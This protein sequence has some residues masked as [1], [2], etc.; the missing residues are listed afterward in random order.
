MKLNWLQSLDVESQVVEAQISAEAEDVVRSHYDIVVWGDDIE[1]FMSEVRY[2]MRN[3][4]G[5]SVRAST[6]ISDEIDS[7]V[8]ELIA[9]DSATRPQGPLQDIHLNEDNP[10]DTPHHQ[11]LLGTYGSRNSPDTVVPN[12]VHTVEITATFYQSEDGDAVVS[13]HITAHER[14]GMT[15]PTTDEVHSDESPEGVDRERLDDVS[16]DEENPGNC[17]V[18]GCTALVVEENLYSH[19]IDAHGW[20]EDSLMEEYKDE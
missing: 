10:S 15:A 19:C 14:S 13:E 20:W 4:S 17:P 6:G 1:D 9:R 7:M 5:S 3:Q 18:D 2:Y 16:V 8:R 11:D 12:N